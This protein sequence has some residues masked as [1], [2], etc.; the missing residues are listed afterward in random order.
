MRHYTGCKP[1]DSGSNP[2]GCIPKRVAKSA[3]GGMTARRGHVFPCFENAQA[4]NMPAWGAGMSPK[5][6]CTR[7][8]TADE[9]RPHLGNPL[10][11]ARGF[12]L[13]GR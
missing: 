5:M 9:S 13:E 1:G 6:G 7:S 10:V 3:S 8:A 12:D 4:Y 11:S 2:L